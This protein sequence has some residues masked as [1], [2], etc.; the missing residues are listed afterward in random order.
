MGADGSTDDPPDTRIWVDL[1]NPTEDELKMLERDFGIL[2]LTTEDLARQGQRA[3][4]EEFDSYDYLVAFDMQFTDNEI[5]TH[6]VDFLI[7]KTFLISSH[8][9]ARHRGGG[10]SMRG[11]N[12]DCRASWRAAWITCSTFSSTRSWIA[13]FRR[14]TPSMKR[15]TG[16]RMRSSRTRRRRCSI[17]SSR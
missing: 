11:S 5:T 9:G 14:S 4:L 16:W 8:R 6:E 10:S 3:K 13:I 12:S 1:D 2:P 17:R 7:G 15:L